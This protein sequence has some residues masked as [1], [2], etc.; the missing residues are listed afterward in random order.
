ML[1]RG[2]ALPTLVDRPVGALGRLQRA[3][4]RAVLFGRRH[5]E[6]H[7]LLPAA[8]YQGEALERFVGAGR[9]LEIAFREPACIVRG[10][11][12]VHAV[13]DIGPIGV[14]VAFF[15]CQRHLRH[16]REGLV[17]IGKEEFAHDRAALA[18][19]APMRHAGQRFLDLVWTEL[20]AH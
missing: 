7:A 19:M 8:G 16:E 13:V 1:C 17:E 15:R 5:R 18:V 6:R 10:K 12:Y 4:C 3:G 2:V 11:G 9:K 20:L 14:V